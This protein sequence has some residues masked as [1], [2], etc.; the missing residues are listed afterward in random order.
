MSATPRDE[1]LVKRKVYELRDYP[2]STNPEGFSSNYKQ[3][4]PIGIDFGSNSIR[5]GIVSTEDP[6]HSFPN[7]LSKY[8]D[9]KLNKSMTFIGND[10]YLD[11]SIKSQARSPYDGPYI[12]NWDYVEQI[13]DYTFNHIGVNS[14]G[15]VDNPVI[16]TEKPAAPLLQRKNFYELL[17]ENYN[18]QKLAIGI[19]GLFSYYQNN[20]SNG[21]VIGTGHEA[22]HVIPVV[23]GKRLNDRNKENKLGW[24][25][26]LQLHGFFTPIEISILPY[27]NYKLSN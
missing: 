5:A 4:V 26:S 8:R 25:S 16:L 18:V 7:L 19:D 27:K 10:V 11:P 13:F 1:S 6:S 14:S 24:T 15:G 22:T 3:N 20:G 9:R 23:K 17:Y 12:T 21:L 2:E